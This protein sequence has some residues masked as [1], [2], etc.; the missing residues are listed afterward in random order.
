MSV[1][2]VN[3]VSMF[4]CLLQ[5]SFLNASRQNK[6]FSNQSFIDSDQMLN[7]PSILFVKKDV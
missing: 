2:K 5:N 4:R 1:V 7:V 3:L 6:I